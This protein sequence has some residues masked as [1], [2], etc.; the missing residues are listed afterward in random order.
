MGL[1]D[2]FC[3]LV[4]WFYSNFWGL[5]IFQ[6]H[7]VI[8]FYLRHLLSFIMRY[9]NT[10]NKKIG[11]IIHKFYYLKIL[12]F[13]MDFCDRHCDAILPLTSLGFSV[14][15]HSEHHIRKSFCWTFFTIKRMENYK[16]WTIKLKDVFK[17][18][19][20]DISWALIW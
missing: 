5:F 4:F 7:I 2:I 1:W 20:C 3:Y 6:K 18:Q 11:I 9:V 16:K 8:D 10:K 14:L 12:L 17:L 19:F 13:N 15:E